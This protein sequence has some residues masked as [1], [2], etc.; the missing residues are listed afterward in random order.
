MAVIINGTTP[1][2][3]YTFKDV[4]V[5]NISEAYLTIVANGQVVMEKDLN[6]AT[7]GDDYLA[8]T[9]TQQETLSMTSTAYMMLNWLLVDGTRGA[10]SKTTVLMDT[11]FKNEVI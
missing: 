11:N 3:Q 7:V 1:T 6:T 8:W 9:L 5:A 2:I 10:S 4:E